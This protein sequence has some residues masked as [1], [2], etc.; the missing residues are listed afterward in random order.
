MGQLEERVY[1]LFGEAGSLTREGAPLY[2]QMQARLRAAVR[3]G[4]LRA[5]E[6]LPPERE[7]ANAMGVSRVTVRRAIDDLV[8]EGLLTQRQGAGTFVTDRVEQP[9]NRLRS[10][11]EIIRERG[12]E[13]GS[14]W[15]E[16]SVAMPGEE[17]KR[18]LA[19][20]DFDE[21]TRFFR[22][23]TADG[24]PMGLELATTPTRFLP[25][26]FEVEGS[27]YQVLGARGLRPVRAL[28][29]LRAVAVD[30]QR[31]AYLDIAPNSAVLYIE[32]LGLLDDGTPVEFTRSWFPGDAY[33]FVVEIQHQTAG[34]P[35]QRQ[36]AQQAGSTEE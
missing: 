25:N 35:A 13:P 22:L 7:I 32:R 16:R 2:M 36:A 21:V 31:A 15:L 11:S 18:A 12:Q 1:G 9:L 28:Q 26:P 6:V 29:R 4:A 30:E 10:F 33:D 23:R 5:G 27:L 3:D 17:E 20:D 19:L 24:K 14:R 8:D 34:V